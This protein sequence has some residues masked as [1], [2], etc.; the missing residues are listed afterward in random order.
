[1][2]GCCGCYPISF[3][4]F[5]AR[6]CTRT[7]QFGKPKRNNTSCKWRLW[8]QALVRQGATLRVSESRERIIAKPPHGTLAAIRCVSPVSGRCNR[9]VS[10]LQ[11]LEPP[12]VGRV[13]LR[14]TARNYSLFRPHSRCAHYQ[15]A[16]PLWFK[17]L[18]FPLSA[19]C[20]IGCAEFLHR[21][22]AAQIFRRVG[23]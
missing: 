2:Q 3:S 18:S 20:C 8:P 1:M 14:I 10:S 7:R 6:D 12:F 11:R 16:V 9:R 23:C 13:T 4:P 21:L 15:G 22:K 19:P 17:P 5:V